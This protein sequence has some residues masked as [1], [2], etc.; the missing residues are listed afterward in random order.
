MGFFSDL[1]E[2][3]TTAVVSTVKRVAAKAINFVAENAEK[4]VGEVKEVWK[5]VKPYIEKAQAPLKMAAASVPH[6]YAKAALTAISKGID[7]LLALENSPI[8]KK[9]GS[10]IESAGKWARKMEEQIKNGEV[11]FFTAEE[12]EQAVGNRDSLRTAEADSAGL[13]AQQ[14][15]GLELANALNDLGIAQ[16][17]LQ[18]VIDS[19]PASYDHY[20][21]LRATQKLLS[22]VKGK[23]VKQKSLDALTADDQFVIRTASDLIKANP[24]LTQASAKRLDS[25]LNENHGKTFQSFVQEEIC[26][27]LTQQ[28]KDLGKQIKALGGEQD[29]NNIAITRLKTAKRVQG[30]LDD[31]EAARLASLEETV[32][33]Q[34]TELKTLRT[35]RHDKEIFANAMEGFL[36]MLE[37]SE[38]QLSEEGREYVIDDGSR[39]GEIIVM[40]AQK[41]TPFEELSDEEQEIIIDFSNVFRKE[42]KSRME[43]VI[44]VTA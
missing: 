18:H 4:F 37:K 39:I 2:S 25:L 1:F 21:R 24:E 35:E 12:Y 16:T 43:S 20:L 31:T 15:A 41:N 27:L 28:A 40:A 19:E 8:A 9:V 26:V 36:Q 10:A 22:A 33:A 3:V 7:A 23:L 11:P 38:E 13:D 32:A 30:E 6:P 5:K 17:D 14:R 42:S 34:E 44:E 29:S